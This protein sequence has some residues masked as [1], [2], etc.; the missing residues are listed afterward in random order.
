MMR[1][2]EGRVE[3]TELDGVDGYADRKEGLEPPRRTRGGGT[4]FD[5]PRQVRTAMRGF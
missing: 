4:V 5:G 3:Q 2:F 1:V